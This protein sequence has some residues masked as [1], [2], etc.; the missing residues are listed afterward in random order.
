MRGKGRKVKSDF[1]GTPH[2]RRGVGGGGESED[3]G[4]FFANFEKND[5][6]RFVERVVFHVIVL[7]S[8]FNE[9]KQ[10]TREKKNSKTVIVLS[11]LFDKSSKIKCKTWTTGIWVTV[12]SALCTR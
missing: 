5:F 8:S 10:K 7:E 12:P 3:N 6:S 11:Q 1:T 2:P 4:E 9:N